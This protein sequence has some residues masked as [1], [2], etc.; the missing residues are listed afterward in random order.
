M[1]ALLC[2]WL[3]AG[4][5]SAQSPSQPP[6][7]AQAIAATE[8]A[9]TAYTFRMDLTDGRQT[10]TAHFDPRTRPHLRLVSPERSALGD[11]LGR[12]YDS[13]AA[14]IEGVFWCARP[15]LAHV[16]NARLVRED[17]STASYVFQPTRENV[18]DQA[19]PIV[20][21]LR[22]ELTMTKAP[23]DILS[24]HIFLPEPFNPA[25]GIHAERF[26]ISQICAIAPNGRRY[27]SEIV[28]EQ[29]FSMFGR[30]YAVRYVRRFS[31]LADV[32]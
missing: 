1:S 24:T 25:L 17:A 31:E 15:T 4:S 19:R 16:S 5:A 27:A 32:R 11:D 2:V 6:G 28:T 23:A 18:A 12:A 20:D 10:A 13:I 22:G 30:D 21:H 26:D 29:R 14:H 3:I 9:K 8:A 7:L